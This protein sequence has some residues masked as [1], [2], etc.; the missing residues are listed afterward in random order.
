MNKPKVGDKLFLVDIGNRARLGSKQRTCEVA[1]VGRKY[2]TVIYG[3]KPHYAEVEFEIE[4]LR[5]RTKYSQE[6]ALYESERAWLDSI[7]AVKWANAIA[8][9]FRYSGYKSFT[10]DQLREVVKILGIKLEES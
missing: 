2:F 1:K 7:L 9:V 3:E 6:Y 10:I 4:T 5:Q 8:D